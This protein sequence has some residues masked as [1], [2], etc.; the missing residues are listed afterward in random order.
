MLLKHVAIETTKNWKISMPLQTAEMDGDV[1]G[2]LFVKPSKK[3][4]VWVCIGLTMHF[5]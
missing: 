4:P 5:M 2:Q 1:E 3:H